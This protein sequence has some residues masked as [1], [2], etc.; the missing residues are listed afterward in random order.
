MG[1]VLTFIGAIFFGA[2]AGA[3]A[4]YVLAVNLARIA[5]LSLAAK[6]TAPKIDLSQA[7]ANKLLTIRSTVQP[8]AFTYGQDMLS[9]PLIFANTTGEGLS[10]LHRLVALHGREIDS[11]V[12]FRIDDTDILIGTDIASDSG[13]VTGGKFADVL[14]IDTRLGTSIQTA[15]PELIAAFPDNWTAAHQCRGWSL[16]FTKM[17]LETGNLA[18]QNGI[19]QNLRAVTNGH[20]VY[21]P[22]LDDTQTG[23]SGTHRLADDSTW[24]F[25]VNPALILSDFLRFENVGLGEEDDRINYTRVITAANICD[26]LVAIPTADTQKRYTCNYTFFANNNRGSIKETIETAMLGRTVFSQ[27]QWQIFAGAPIT[28][29]VTLTEANLSAGSLQLQASSGSSERF[30]RVRGKFIDPTRNYT[31]N[32]YPEQRNATFELEDNVV[33]YLIFD[34][35]AVNNSFEA[36]RDAIIKLR[37]SRNQRI[38]VFPG[39]WSCFRIQPGSVVLLDIAELGFTGEKFFVTEWS[40]QRDGSGVSLTLVEEDDTVWTAPV[41]ADYTVRTITGELIFATQGAVKLTG[42]NLHNRRRE[43]TVTAGLQL[44]ASGE[45]EYASPAGVFSTAGTPPNEWL[46]QP[47]IDYFVRA[48]LNSGTLTTGTV[49]IFE[50]LAVS[51][52]WTV[53]ETVAGNIAAAN[54]TLE[55]AS[56]ASGVPIV[57]TATF[58]LE[59]DNFETAPVLSAINSVATRVFQIGFS[60]NAMV[61]FNANGN[62]TGNNFNSPDQINLLEWWPDEPEAGIGVGFDVRCKQ[63]VEGPLWAAEPAAIGV[64]TTMNTSRLWRVNRNSANDGVGETET[65][66]IFEI[67]KTGPTNP[68]IASATVK[69]TAILTP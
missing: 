18:F 61:S 48:T 46:V 51:R 20:L 5:L 44:N 34:T 29:D 39:N 68:V 33:R 65:V 17:I 27:G 16:L 9:G 15:I 31:A 37:Q 6:L 14:D 58:D 52:S 11:F 57:Q 35:T 32:S 66:A 25:S 13:P 2:A 56:A 38:M 21:D 8:Q 22:R 24:E 3:S 49:D 36:Q 62:I 40:L 43:Q 67:R 26:E 54:I 7:A 64:F 59:A 41:E 47:G 42:G 4:A 10:E 63:I 23:G 30:N 45:L 53:V 55:I 50:A 12:S 19:P 69:V 28:A 1:P 60:V